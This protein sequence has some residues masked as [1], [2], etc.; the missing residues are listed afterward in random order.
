MIDKLLSNKSVPVH[1]FPQTFR[2]QLMRKLYLNP[3]HQHDKPL[4][5]TPSHRPLDFFDENVLQKDR[6]HIFVLHRGQT[7]KY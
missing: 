5:V 4:K 3:V 2:F 1:I 7:R 6:L